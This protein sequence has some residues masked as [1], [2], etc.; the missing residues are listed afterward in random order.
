MVTAAD[1]MR[2][3]SAFPPLSIPRDGRGFA[4]ALII[5]IVV[6]LTGWTPEQIT[7]VLLAL[8]GTPVHDR[9]CAEARR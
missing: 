7:M 3:L 8:A 4:T 1:P 5:V 9:R 2:C 6:V